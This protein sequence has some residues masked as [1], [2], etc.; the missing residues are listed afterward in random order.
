MYEQLEKCKAGRKLLIANACRNDPISGSSLAG[1]KIKLVDDYPENVP[2]GIAALFSC[3]AGQKS[4]FDA[5]RKRSLFFIHLTEAWRGNYQPGD[6][7]LTLESVFETTRAKTKADA[8]KTFGE[9]QYPVV[10]RQYEGEWVVARDLGSVKEPKAGEEREF[11]IATGV[12]MVFCWIP[13]GESQLGSPKEEQDYITKTFHKGKRLDFLDSETESW[14]GKFKTKGIWLGKYS[15]TQAEWKALMG[16]NPSKFDGKKDN[17]AKGL[18]TSRFPVEQV[19]WN[20]I[21]QGEGCFLEKLN[22]RGGVVKVFGKDC[23]FMLPNEDQWEYACR[24]GKGNKRPFY[25]GD[26]LNGTQANCNG[27][28]PYGTTTK[29]PSLER[30]C[31]VDF[32]NGGKYEKHPWGLYHMIGNVYQWCDNVYDRSKEHNVLRGG[33]YGNGAVLCRSASRIGIS[34]GF[35]SSAVYGFRV[36]LSLDK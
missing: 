12:K 28:Y 24:G 36:C 29:V 25:W 33:S 16:V 18:D 35:S 11:E 17:K 19:S 32:T 7:P 2:K 15:V 6:G 13:P 34:P 23:K 22:M 14:R 1:D 10:R 20:M 8:N 5:D 30:T 9:K 4:Y 26:E 31:A 3:E 27:D 21:A